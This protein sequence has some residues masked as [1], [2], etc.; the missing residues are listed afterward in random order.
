MRSVRAL[1]L[2]SIFSTGILRKSCG[3][4]VCGDSNI[5]AKGDS[6]SLFRGLS[7]RSHPSLKIKLFPFPYIM[8]HQFRRLR[9]AAALASPIARRGAG[10]GGRRPRHGSAL[11]PAPPPLS[12]Q[13][14]QPPAAGAPPSAAGAH[15]AA[16]LSLRA[17]PPPSLSPGRQPTWQRLSP[18]KSRVRDRAAGN[19]RRLY[20]VAYASAIMKPLLHGIPLQI[21]G[22]P[23][24]SAVSDVSLLPE[25]AHVGSHHFARCPDVLRK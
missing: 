19:Q 12:S 20:S 18:P 10:G 14:A 1:V 23:R 17:P 3:P 9:P 25:L 5:G 4:S 21:N 2:M 24:I 22:L 13:A 16:Q 15:G 7:G 8:P 6:T 11:R